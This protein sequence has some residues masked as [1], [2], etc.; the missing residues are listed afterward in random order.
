MEGGEGEEVEEEVEEVE[1]LVQG[2]LG[3]GVG[4]GESG[5]GGGEGVG[6]RGRGEGGV[7]GEDESRE[8]GAELGPVFGEDGVANRGFVDWCREGQRGYS[9]LRRR[10][11]PS[12]AKAS[13]RWLEV[14]PSRSLPVEM[15]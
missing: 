4:E 2:G 6:G 3:G 14:R 9:V 1:G 15:K 7:E 10:D 5:E 8:A 12:A 13:T 11:V